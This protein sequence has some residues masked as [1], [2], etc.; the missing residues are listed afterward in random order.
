MTTD[1]IKLEEKLLTEEQVDLPVVHK[2]AKGMYIRELF[3]PK[4]TVLVGKRHRHHTLNMLTKGKML[5]YDGVNET[6]EV[7]A[8]YTVESL[9]LT[10]KAGYALEDSLWVNIHV[11]D[12]TDLDKIEEEFIITEEEFN[13]L[14]ENKGDTKCLG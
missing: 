11:T 5:I 7:E 2:F 13:N 3:I 10:K 4:G 14:I 8:P 6:I 9:P 1:I 12:E